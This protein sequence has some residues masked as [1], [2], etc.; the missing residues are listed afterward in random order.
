MHLV[1]GAFTAAAPYV[2][3]WQAGLGNGND[4]GGLI[5]ATLA[6]AG[7]FGKFLVVC[8][9]LA[10]PSASTP[11]MYTVCTSLMTV[12]HGF[13]RV[14]RFLLAIVSTAMYVNPPAC[15][16]ASARFI[17]W[18]EAGSGRPLHPWRPRADRR[19]PLLLFL[20]D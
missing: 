18:E 1:A 20:A 19:G 9:A 13:A 16:P 15:S 6:P 7:G 12:W 10:T 4:V 2:P 14:P 11:A 5:A 17:M 3:A 8:M